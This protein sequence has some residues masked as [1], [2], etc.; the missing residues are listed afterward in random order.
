MSTKKTNYRTITVGGKT[1]KLDK[2]IPLISDLP[3]SPKALEKALKRHI[4]KAKT[5]RWSHAQVAIPASVDLTQLPGAVKTRLAIPLPGESLGDES[6]RIG[7]MHSHTRGPVHLVH[8]DAHAPTKNPIEL[9]RHIPESLHALNVRRTADPFVKAAS[10]KERLKV[11]YIDETGAGHRAQAN[12]VVRA[13]RKM[14]IDAEAVDFANTFLKKKRDGK[15]YRQAYLNY[16]SKKSIDTLPRLAKA[17]IKYHQGVDPKKRAKFLKENKDAALLLAH[18]H[19]EHQFKDLKRPVSVMHTDPVKWPFSFSPSAKGKRLHIGSSG[20]I[21]NMPTPNKKEVSGLAVHP[22]LLSKK[23]SRSGL[24]KKK[25]FNITVSAGG[26]ALE[27]PEIVEQVLKSDLPKNAVVHAV[28]G[29]REDVLNKLQ[30]MAKKDKRLQPHGFAPL[31]KM[32]READLNVIRAHGT[33]Y[34]ETLTSGKPAVYYGPSLHLLDLQ[35]TLTRRTAVHGGKETQYPVAVGLQQIPGAVNEAQKNYKGLRRQAKKLQKNYGDPASQIAI[36]AVKEARAPR[37]YKREYAQYHGK[38]EQVANRSMRN[39]A[40]RKLGLKNGDPREVDHR[41]PLSKGGGN[42][43]SNL[44]AI[45][46]RANRTKFN[47]KTAKAL[48]FGEAALVRLGKAGLAEKYNN[49]RSDRLSRILQTE[50]PGT[51]GIHLPYPEF[52]GKGGKF[53]PARLN[54]LNYKKSVMNKEQIR[55]LSDQLAHPET[56]VQVAIPGSV[57]HMPI[58]SNIKSRLTGLA[59]LAAKAGR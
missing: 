1:V 59:D 48:T 26:E 49:L 12:N 13:A 32:M 51:R 8:L 30:A 22:D 2:E 50:I 55:N 10:T 16:L 37:D 39:Q 14:G 43:K 17:H 28:A 15:E 23:M 4:E 40:R 47:E 45:S 58:A 44:R 57:L 5:T 24:M 54:P 34:A 52:V 6:L 7:R 11:L 53:S 38:P 56:A 33:S 41:T 29:R 19:L 20:V 31:P 21:G 3:S 46:R 42:G 18:P 27:V 9:I 25:D 36:A 35:G